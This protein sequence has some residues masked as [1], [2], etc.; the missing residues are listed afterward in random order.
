MWK[1][2]STAGQQQ[3]KRKLNENTD[4]IGTPKPCSYCCNQICAIPYTLSQYCGNVRGSNKIILV[5]TVLNITLTYNDP[6]EVI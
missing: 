6:H 1:V 5:S 3:K 4:L 2:C